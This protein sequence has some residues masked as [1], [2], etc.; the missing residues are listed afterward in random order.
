[1]QKTLL[2]FGDSNTHGT[3]PTPELGFRGRFG[4]D[5]RWPCVAA[6]A[7]G[8]NWVL[9]EEGL[10]GRTATCLTDPVMGPQMNGQLGLKIALQ[11]HGPIDVLAIML[12]TNDCKTHFGLTAEGITG[13]LA[14][15]LS[16]AKDPEMQARH[17][18]FEILLIAPPTIREEGIY[19][20]GLM[21]AA[22]KSAALPG[23]YARLAAHN[24]VHFLDASAH[25][26]CCA[27]DGVHFDASAHLTLGRVVAKEIAAW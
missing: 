24:H 7:L 2:T 4:A 18:G 12:G 20:D 22:T 23:H 8:P 17:A 11:S 3:M 25:I 14:A 5:A 1:M 15:L 10:P 26:R 9:I 21:D 19:V 6:Q 27:E 16:I 13:H